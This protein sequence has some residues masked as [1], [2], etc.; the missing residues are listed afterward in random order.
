M[1][2]SHAAALKLSEIREK[3]NDLNAV[4]EPTD[5][6]KTEERELLAAQ[7]T[8]E[9]EYREALT[10]ES[11][12]ETQP[13]TADP[14]LRERL[15]L[16]RKSRLGA[17]ILAHLQGREPNGPEAEYRSALGVTGI[18]VDL[19]EREPEIRADAASVAPATGMGS[20][21]AP[22]Q[23]ALFAPSIAPRLGIDMPTVGSGAYSEARISTS[24]TAGAKAKGA[25]QESTAAVLTTVTA[26]PRAITG[27]LTLQLEDIAL[28]GQDNFEAA[29]RSNLQM[30]LSHEYDGQT[31]NGN[32]TAP[33]VNGLIKQLT[34]PANPTEIAGF[35][36][37]LKSFSDAIDGLWASELR[38]IAI[39]ANVD[40]YKRSARTF[41][42]FTKETNT[43]AAAARGAVSF[44]DYA[45]ANTAGWWCNSRMPATAANIARGIVHRRGRPGVRTAVHPVWNSITIDDVYT[46]AASRQR[47]VTMSVL[48]GDKVIL[49]QP[50]AYALAEWKVA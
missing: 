15:E 30:A 40:A 11:E 12:A 46:D 19:F 48:V 16:R 49:V 41:R 45:K 39:V 42:D 34:D 33:N 43:A 18:P 3:L 25:A 17:F 36:D 22:I 14:E 10:A 20:T 47:H 50:A 35:D 13:T 29:L 23:P 1:L 4:V 2:K 44:A 28:I 7:K 24:L 21:L 6:Q 37:Y 32:G 27:R 26:N 38:E 9:T 31:V 5:A 8:T